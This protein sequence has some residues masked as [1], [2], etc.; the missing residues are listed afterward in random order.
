M[1]SERYANH[2]PCAMAA[3]GRAIAHTISAITREISR[4]FFMGNTS[5]EY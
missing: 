5:C 4:V 3:P 1:R 2:T